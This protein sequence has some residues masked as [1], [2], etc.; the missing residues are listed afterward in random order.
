MN[1]AGETLACGTGACAAVVAGIR[2][3]CSM[4]V[5]MCIPAAAADHRLEGGAQDRA[6]DRPAT[7][8][9]EGQ[10]DIPDAL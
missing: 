9:F 8:V 5:S 4:R 7:T 2:W 3:A 6:H 1:A 10:I